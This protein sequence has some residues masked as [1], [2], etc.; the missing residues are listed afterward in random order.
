MSRRLRVF[1]ACD[2]QTYQVDGMSNAQIF[3]WFQSVISRD[4]GDQVE[5]VFV[6][7]PIGSRISQA[8]KDAIRMA[9][10]AICVFP[11][12]SLDQVTRRWTT[13]SYVLSES[14]YAL[15]CL[16]PN[17]ES[18]I[19]A[20]V[21]QDVDCDQLGV[22]FSKDHP[23][24]TFD[25]NR[26][27]ETALPALRNV[28]R[29]LLKD[30][31]HDDL[32]R[33]ELL[34]KTITIYR[35]GWAKIEAQHRFRMQI[36]G[37]FERSHTAWRVREPL[38]SIDKLLNA[39]PAGDQPFLLCVPTI[40][41]NYALLDEWP[42]LRPKKSVN[43]SDQ[44]AMHFSVAFPNAKLKVGNVVEY[45]LAWQY[46]NAFASIDNYDKHQSAGLWT[47]GSRSIDRVKLKLRFERNIEGG[48]RLPAISK[49][50]C[51]D[52]EVFQRNESCFPCGQDIVEFW[53]HDALWH[54]TGR[55]IAHPSE[56]EA[57]FE[58]YS[59]TS[60]N[61]SGMAKACWDF[62]PNYLQPS[63]RVTNKRRT[64]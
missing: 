54:P 31:P 8:V 19:F 29:N 58:C 6:R 60:D 9:D 7:D 42:L 46:P 21:E 44:K 2:M 1:L 10:C 32:P 34:D 20:F 13:S 25:R 38:P 52:F 11:R 50:S 26:L 59:W 36:D 57:L 18:K 45:K 51:D 17:T 30:L 49:K 27:E 37:E 14:G 22:A 24:N 23:L 4:Y 16:E 41:G 62:S 39:R 61:F 12:R 33:H 35:S 56:Q 5:I 55:L 40:V 64:E 3:E 43:P 47:C 48:S 53:H 15:C 63:N 28:I